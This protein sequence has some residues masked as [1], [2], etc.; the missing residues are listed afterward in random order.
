M[1]SIHLR[2]ALVVLLLAVAPVLADGPDWFPFV[3]PWDDA[4]PTVTNV[5][6][7][8]PTPAGNNGVVASRDGHF[9]DEK[10]RRVRF[11]GVNFCYRANFPDKADAEKVA[12]RLR[13]YGINI[14]RLHALDGDQHLGSIFDPAFK[15][16]QHFDKDKLDRLDYLVAQLKR[17]GI[18]VNV[19]LHV[20][21]NFTAADGL[22]EPE[23]LRHGGGVHYFD[24]RVIE[25]QKKYAR[26]LLTHTNPYTKTRYAEEPAVAVVELTNESTLVGAAWG[27]K[28]RQ[29]PPSYRDELTRQWNAWLKARYTDTD[30]LKKAWKSGPELLRAGVD[31]WRLEQ[32][33]GASAS[34]KA[35]TADRLPA[36]AVGPVLRIGVAKAGKEAWHLQVQQ[37][38]LDLQDGTGYTLIFWARADRK[39][40]LNIGA[41]LD[42]SDYRNVGLNQR[43]LLETE[44]KQ[45]RLPFVASR[46]LKGHT[47]L[48]FAL[49]TDGGTIDI[50]GVSLRTGS[51]DSLPADATLEK[52]T[53]PLGA[54]TGGPAGE[55]W[56][57]FLIDTERRYLTTMRDYLKKDLGVRANVVCSQTGWGGL[58]GLMR[59]RHADLADMHAYWQHPRFPR[60]AWDPADWVIGNTS[61]TRDKFGGTF[62]SLARFR[63]A[64][65]P[66]TISEYSHP[67]PNDFQAEC[68]PMLAAFAAA[69]DWDGIYLFDYNSDGN[70]NS[71]RIRGFFSI[72]SNPAQL[73]FL[74]A[75]A[76]LFLRGDIAPN[77]DY[78]DLLIPEG[79][80]ALAMLS[81]KNNMGELWDVAGAR[82]LDFLDKRLSVE[83]LPG[84]KGP[85]KLRR[86][87]S[88]ATKGALSWQGMGTEQALFTADARQSKVI[89]GF[90]GGR[91]VDL[92]GWQLQAP[93]K[94]D[95]FAALTLTAMD[96]KP[97]AEARSLLLTAV[98]RVANKDMGWNAERTSVGKNWGTGP[99]RAQ[100]IAATVRIDTQARTAT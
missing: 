7:L 24:P 42:Q 84:E 35:L 53:V 31:S 95:G 57:A 15:D 99:T 55:D 68:L 45:F 76:M 80:A 86:G 23:K 56:M 6:A 78:C 38:G 87:G 39:R 89:V 17:N 44:W 49:G 12:A 62:P 60:R 19:N 59:E 9:Y 34:L 70:W 65:Q 18:Y 30:G 94:G 83:V 88:S 22:P 28:L 75:A 77:A 46:T 54:V 69:Q 63:L 1:R 4:S 58:G 51:G 32:H 97:I 90:V 96:A 21:R 26:D 48:S 50:V 93:K 79:G 25:L 37:P 98:G 29:L 3:I 20:T 52:G 11:L 43:L 5:S 74:P 47:R 2:N 36:G 40:P 16:T 13:K 71:D 67:A 100:G 66:Y 91:T 64:R 33:Q 92:P 8:N 27:D 10:G 81:T 61:M 73:A 85:P 14:V 82:P 72:D 41:S